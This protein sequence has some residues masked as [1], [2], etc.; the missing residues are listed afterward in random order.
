MEILVPCFAVY[1]HE[2]VSSADPRLLGALRKTVSPVLPAGGGG[3]GSGGVERMDETH[4]S[5][6]HSLSNRAHWKCSRNSLFRGSVL[7]QLI[8]ILF[9]FLKQETVRHSRYMIWLIFT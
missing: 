5:V 8:F 9:F 1:A 7:F 3:G 2:R 4:L 6:L